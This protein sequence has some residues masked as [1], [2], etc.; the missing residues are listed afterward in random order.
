VEEHICSKAPRAPKKVAEEHCLAQANFPWSANGTRQIYLSELDC[1]HKDFG[2]ADIDAWIESF[3]NTTRVVV[4]VVAS[5][6]D[7]G[8]N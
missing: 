2:W 4:V 3:K 1:Y 7:A 8:T 6:V 5:V